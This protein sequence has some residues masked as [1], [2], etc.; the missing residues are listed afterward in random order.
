MIGGAPR[1][2]TTMPILL[3][4]AL[5]LIL[6]HPDLAAQ[7]TNEQAP[8]TVVVGLDEMAALDR[9][10]SAFV[11][12]GLNLSEGSAYGHIVGLGFEPDSSEVE[13]SAR[14]EARGQ[15]SR[16]SLSAAAHTG[17]IDPKVLRARLEHLAAAIAN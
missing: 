15:I 10:A 14:V 8:I 4:L 11:Q 1:L 5:V 13:Y 12:T 2:E 17:A 16:V 7:A 9:V 3:P 6:A